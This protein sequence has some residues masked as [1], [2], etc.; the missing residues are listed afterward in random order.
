M[1]KFTLYLVLFSSPIVL[2]SEVEAV[3]S[4]GTC[5]SKDY[6]YN[7][8]APVG[9]QCN[10]SCVQFGDCCPDFAAV[11]RTCAVRNLRIKVEHLYIT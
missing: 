3:P 8:Q 2:I 4:N 11:C 7:G 1:H 10:E 6:C 9:C 5:Q